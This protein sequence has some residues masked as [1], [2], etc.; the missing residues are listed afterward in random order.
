[1]Y[2]SLHY[3]AEQD[4]VAPSVTENTFPSGSSNGSEY[5]KQIVI[6]DDGIRE[7]I[8]EDFYLAL[9]TTDESVVLQPA[10]AQVLIVDNDSK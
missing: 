2:Q 7:E 10:T 3:L 5:C 4:Y 8:H 1:M 9:N 6:V